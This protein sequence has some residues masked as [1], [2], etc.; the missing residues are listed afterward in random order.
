MVPSR[1]AG[2]YRGRAQRSK[3][4][5]DSLSTLAA[6]AVCGSSA[7]AVEGLLRFIKLLSAY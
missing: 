3:V 5:R 2:A 4:G 7:A 1:F 6:V